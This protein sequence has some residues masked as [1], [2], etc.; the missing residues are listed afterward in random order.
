MHRQL[1]DA[2]EIHAGYSYL[3]SRSSP[4]HNKR[5][6]EFGGSVENRKL[7]RR[8]VIDEV[9]KQETFFPSSSQ[10]I[11][12]MEGVTLEDTLNT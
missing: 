4:D 2:V 10:C 1:V 9:R 11:E 7:L 12:L 8:M 6:D 5:T 3:I